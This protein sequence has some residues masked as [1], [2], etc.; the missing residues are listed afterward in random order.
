ML[1]EQ[2]SNA[3]GVSGN[4]AEVR[5]IIVDAVRERVDEYRIDTLGNLIA[6]KR[7]VGRGSRRGAPRVMVAAHMD[8]VGLLIT[9]VDNDGRLRF[10][11]VGG[12]DD[13]VLLSKVFLIGK[14]SVPGV[15]GAIPPHK[16]EARDRDKVI[17][18][19][20]M[21]LDIGA[22]SKEDA[23]DAIHI[24]DYATFATDFSRLGDNVVR[25]K[26]LDDRTGCSLLVDLLTMDYP[27]DLYGVFTVQEEVG[28]R[29]ARVA[30]YSVNPDL[31]F[32]LES[33]VCDDSPKEKDVSPTTRMGYGPAITIADRTTVSDKRLVELLTR[34]ATENKIPFQ[35]KGPLVGGTDAARIH[36]AR[37]G[38]PTAAV[39]VP[40][41][42]IHSPAALLS[43]TDYE[44][45]R[46]VMAQALPQ[47]QH[48]LSIRE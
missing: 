34:T 46:L 39:S 17:H 29:G 36:L 48:G 13:R 2:L 20:D 10:A 18:A 15:I 8:E 11:K 12:I 1:L 37:G 7:G 42:Y 5:Q 23:L 19:D 26:A 33:T 40:T 24:G 27:F 3:R 28:V 47:L 38:I 9:H 4:E 22:K 45:A 16:T 41:R 6:C 14:D 32:V 35:F 30:A 25:G 44:N 43:L 21:T 31:A